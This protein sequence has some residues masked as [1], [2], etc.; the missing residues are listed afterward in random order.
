MRDPGAIARV[1]L[2]YTLPFHECGID[3]RDPQCREIAK[4]LE[5]FYF[6][7]SGLSEKTILVYLMVSELRFVL[8]HF[9]KAIINF[10]DDITLQRR[11]MT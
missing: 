9:F 5:K 3:V 10:N 4:N 2:A 8:C 6:G 11:K 7:F 1:N